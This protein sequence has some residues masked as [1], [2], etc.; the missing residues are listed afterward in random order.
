MDQLAAIKVFVAIADAGSLS[1]AGRRLSMPLTTVS[2]HLAALEDEVGT[3]LIIRTT[4]D[5]ALTETGR[6]YLESC[7]RILAELDAARLRVMGEQDEPQ[8]E[9]AITAPVAFG[10]LHVLPIVTAFLKTS[11]RVAVRLLLIDRVVDLLEEGIDI[12]LRVGSLP[13]SSLRA[14]RVGAVRSVTCANAGYLTALTPADRWVYSGPKASQR[15]AVRPR[16]IVNT[17]EAAIDAAR[18]GLGVTRVLSYQAA[19][20]VAEG[21]LRLILRDFE[22]EPIPVNLL[23]REDRLPQ[24]KVRSFIAFA[25]PRLRQVLKTAQN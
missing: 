6:N 14:A 18:E 9:L 10:R 1:A 25:A 24:A 15:V 17:A 2:R 11:P 21:S 20:L 13:D 4:R 3:R 12:S 23:H 8:G 22:P 7:R 19:P 16:L 5:L